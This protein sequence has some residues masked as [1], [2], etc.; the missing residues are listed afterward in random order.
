MVIH[1]A[2]EQQVFKKYPGVFRKDE[3]NS[4]ENLRGIPK[5]INNTVH[6]RDIRKD[7]DSFYKSNP[8]TTPSTR[9]DLLDKATEI[10]NKYGKQFDPPVR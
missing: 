10:D 9:K 1:H 4:V 7:W 5:K 2:V 8:T 6:L 3:I